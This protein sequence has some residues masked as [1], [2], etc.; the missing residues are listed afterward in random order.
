MNQPVEPAPRPEP[1]VVV[2]LATRED[3][4]AVLSVVKG[5]FAARPPV[6]PPAAALSDTLEDVLRA[7]EHGEIVLA[8]VDGV[9]AASLQVSDPVREADGALVAGM[10]RVSVLP[11]FR[12]LGL[13]AAIIRAG[14][15]VATD[16]GAT[17]LQL[18]SRREFPET[19]RMWQ[20]RGFHVQREVPLGH[21]M[22][23]ALP[24]RTEVVDGPA[25]QAL[26]QA[27]G[28]TLQAGDLVVATG[29][30]GAGKTTFTQ[31][32]AAG[33]GVEGQVISPTFVLSRVHRSRIG[34]PDL[35]HVDAYRLGSA[36]EVD[37][38]DLDE[39]M[40]TSVTVV[41][42]GL[43]LA[44]GLADSVL[45]VEI[46]RSPDPDDETRVVLVW[47]EGPR[48]ADLDLGA[49]LDRGLAGTKGER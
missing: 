45:Y 24:V 49:A 25:M 31:G 27:L 15:I 43:G 1:E 4:E 34:G 8:E 35:V 16:L 33:L 42:W 9:P 47:G 18:L 36:A 44:E 3:A 6:E 28:K 23:R 38:L 22:R 29:E 5:A 13:A 10:H 41:E 37:D 39:T 21:V 48:W 2:R 11:Q 20:S 12:H 19:L 46:L 17:H 32:M 26:G 40:A 30:L 14:V 7:L